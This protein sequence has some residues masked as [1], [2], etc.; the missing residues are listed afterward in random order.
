MSEDDEGSGF[1][2]M[3]WVVPLV[4]VIYVLSVGPAE[5]YID[6]NSAL[7]SFARAFYAPLL[8][9]YEHSTLAERFFDWWM[10]VWEA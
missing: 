3:W 4:F 8:W 10:G 6:G 1:R 2:K 9:L 7:G 5:A